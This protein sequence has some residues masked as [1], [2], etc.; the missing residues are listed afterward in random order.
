MNYDFDV[1]IV[2]N[3]M[4]QRFIKKQDFD[5]FTVMSDNELLS[6]KAYDT[7]IIKVDTSIGKSSMILLNVIYILDVL[8]NIVAESILADKEIHF[9][10]QHCHL[11]RNDSVV[12]LM[13]RINAHYVLENNRKFK[14]V[15]ATF[16]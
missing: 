2:N 6:I 5:E 10:I 11:H 14:E 16:I 4:K 13:L 8:I 12:Y 9:D 3:I 1:H 7:I 15:F